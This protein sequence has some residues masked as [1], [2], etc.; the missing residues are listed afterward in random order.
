MP[1]LRKTKPLGHD[2]G[3]VLFDL[4]GED[5]HER[6]SLEYVQPV[7]G[8]SLQR[9]DIDRVKRS[10][11]DGDGGIVFLIFSARVWFDTTERTEEV[12]D[13]LLVEAVFTQTLLSG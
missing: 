2:A 8:H 5:F 12:R 4:F 11:I 10:D 7:K 13:G 1:F 3:A 9:A 6:L